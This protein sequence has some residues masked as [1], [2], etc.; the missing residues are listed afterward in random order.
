MDCARHGV[1]GPPCDQQLEIVSGDRIYACVATLGIHVERERA[2][3]FLLR[4]RTLRRVGVQPVSAPL[5]QRRRSSRRRKGSWSAAISASSNEEQ[6]EA[7]RSG[8][9]AL[10]IKRAESIV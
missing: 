9:R 10:R 4:F 2:G 3:I 6:E 1:G 8:L 5:T 7:G